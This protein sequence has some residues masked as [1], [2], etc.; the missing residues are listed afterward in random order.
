MVYWAARK[1]VF[2][3]RL[4]DQPQHHVYRLS[5]QCWRR[6]KEKSGLSLQ[7]YIEFL[8]TRTREG[9][10]RFLREEWEA[11]KAD[12]GFLQREIP[13]RQTLFCLTHF[14][15][16]Q[17]QKP[18]DYVLGW[19]PFMGL[20]I[21]TEPPVLI[22]RADTA[23]WVK[24]LVELLTR[25]T[26]PGEEGYCLELPLRIL[27]VGTGTGCIVVAMARALP[28]HQYTAI[29]IS[30]RAV[31][32]AR[33][34][35]NANTTPTVR[36]LRYNVQ[37]PGLLAQLGPF[38]M[39]VCN[40]PYVAARDRSTQIA[41]SVRKWESHMALIGGD[42]VHGTSFQKRLLELAQHLKGRPGVPRLAMELNGTEGQAQQARHLGEQFGLAKTQLIRDPTN[43]RP[44]ALF[45]T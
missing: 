11:S 25:A 31:R 24:A 33:A 42:D 1:Y 32:L 3:A 16:Y 45:F 9:R 17:R 22:P 4:A 43:G 29:D 37:E 34:N 18:I 44:R 38:D 30:N 40:P 35:A 23:V 5:Q 36:I 28:Q 10:H 14:Q 8:G 27:E 26:E 15:M 6:L 39:I 12:V 7:R 2:L 13:D 21:R 19:T 41:P 20:H